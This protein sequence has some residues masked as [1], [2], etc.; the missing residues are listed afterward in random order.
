MIRVLIAD[1]H[2]LLRRGLRQLIESI[3]DLQVVG[4][5]V[6][7]DDVLAAV[8]ECRRTSSSST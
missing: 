2:A 5:V 3:P 6:T 8:L 4:E 1:D 7:G